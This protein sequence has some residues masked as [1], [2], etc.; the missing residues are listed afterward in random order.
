MQLLTATLTENPKTV[1][2]KYGDRLVA[3]AKTE[4]GE[5]LA[6]WRPANDPVLGSL[7]LGSSVVLA[8]D[9]K[10]KISLVDSPATEPQPTTAAKSATMTPETK[11]AIAA[12]VEEQASL[13]NFCYQMAGQKVEGLPAEQKREVATTLFIQAN[14]HF[15]L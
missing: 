5:T 7:S 10:G 9:S 1:T 6:V 11:R 14:R 4:A 2:T 12:Y 3:D 8:K 13:F 15:N